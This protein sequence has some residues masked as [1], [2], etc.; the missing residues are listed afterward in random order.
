MANIQSHTEH[1]T[2]SPK[3]NFST[4]VNMKIDQIQYDPLPSH[5]SIMLY[6][7]KYALMPLI[8]LIHAL[9]SFEIIICMLSHSFYEATTNTSK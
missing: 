2:Y 8:F 4:G 9:F 6:T 1:N 3:W 5:A 7:I